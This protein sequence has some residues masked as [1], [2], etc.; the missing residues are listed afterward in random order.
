MVSRKDR[1]VLQVQTSLF[2]ADSDILVVLLTA[3]DFAFRLLASYR[4]IHV[5]EAAFKQAVRALQHQILC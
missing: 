4:S 3:E 1:G 2:Y 5:Q